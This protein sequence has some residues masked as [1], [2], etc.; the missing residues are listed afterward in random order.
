MKKLCLI[1]RKIVLIIFI[2]CLI[3][4]EDKDQDNQI[5]GPEIEWISGGTTITYSYISGI[6]SGYF[7]HRSFNVLNASGEVTIDVQVE[8]DVDTKVSTTINV[9]KGNLYGVTVKGSIAGRHMS[10]PGTTCLNVVFSSPNSSKTQKISVDSYLV[11]SF[12]EYIPDY[13]YCANSLNFG[14]INLLD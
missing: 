8:D 9:E 10:S 11:Q 3:C 7:F 5:S 1:S 13:Y 2:L 6:L 4:C 14:E 12:N